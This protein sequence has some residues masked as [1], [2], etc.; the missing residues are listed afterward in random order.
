MTQA[1]AA[2]GH[3]PRPTA[4]ITGGTRGLGRALVGAFGREGYRVYATARDEDALA[5]L[6][7]AARADDLDVV[8]VRSDVSRPEDN[9]RLVARVA[10][11]ELAVDVLIHNASLLGP[12]VEL[13]AYPVDTFDAVMAV[14]VRGP[15][16]LTRQ[17]LPCLAPGAAI[18]FVSSG[19][20]TGP[21]ARWGAYNVSKIALDGLAGIW[22]RELAGQSLR[23]FI[24]D[25]GPM[26]TEMRAAAYPDED[27]MALAEPGERTGI[28]LW[29]ATEADAA[30]SGR[31]F[32]AREFAERR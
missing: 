28:F 29:L 23:V 3:R 21:R 4:V 18:Q 1:R 19:A 31:R 7:A 14:N 32:E 22:A 25:P 16:D 20:S 10:D 30:L 12:R 17:M 13:A 15:F 24:V 26:R 6:D 11:D 8:A 27:P 5:A 2:T 9:A